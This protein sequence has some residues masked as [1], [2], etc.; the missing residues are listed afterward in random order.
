MKQDDIERLKHLLWYAIP[1][2]T[3]ETCDNHTL[4]NT[5]DGDL[6]VCEDIANTVV[7]FID[8]LMDSKDRGTVPM[9]LDDAIKILNENNHLHSGD[10]YATTRYDVP[11]TTNSK[12]YRVL[13]TD[14]AIMIAMGYVRNGK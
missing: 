9:R 3:C 14:G 11:C 4:K 8:N 7:E 10:W 12:N 6:E 5:I 13:S 1:S 2:H